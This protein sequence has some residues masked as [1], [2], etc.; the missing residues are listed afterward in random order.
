VIGGATEAWGKRVAFEQ[1][2]TYQYD[3]HYDTENL[4]ALNLI[5]HVFFEKKQSRSKTQ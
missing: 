3:T 5:L 1:N 4:W 2:I